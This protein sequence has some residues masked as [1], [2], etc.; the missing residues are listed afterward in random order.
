[1]VLVYV[2]FREFLSV[3]VLHMAGLMMGEVF[4]R[5]INE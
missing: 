3:W 2:E 5:M 4:L 1:M